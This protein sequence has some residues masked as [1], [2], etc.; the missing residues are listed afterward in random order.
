VDL[1]AHPSAI[2]ALRK[3]AIDAKIRLS[4]KPT[5]SFDFELPNGERYQREIPRAVFEALIEPVLSRTAGPCRQAMT[6]AGVTADQI[7]E[8]VLV[9][10]STRIPAC[11]SWLTGFSASACAARGR[12]PS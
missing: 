12:T 3:N 5:A 10:G 1:R 4:T 2:Q 7:D 8:V 11:A 6:D 9:G